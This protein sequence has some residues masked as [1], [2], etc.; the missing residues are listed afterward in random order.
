MSALFVLAL[1]IG[2]AVILIKLVM[3]GNATQ[4]K[5]SYKT[6]GLP[7]GF[8]ASH[9]HKNIAIDAGNGLLWVRDEK[10]FSTVLKASD[11]VRWNIDSMTGN[12]AVTGLPTRANVKLVITSRDLDHP[13]VRVRFN[14]HSDVTRGGGNSNYQEAESWSSRLTA[15]CAR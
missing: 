12:N 15:F 4:E 5:T 10:G 11:V 6:S 8:N 14:G 2:G 13:I 9:S 7:A 1:L 3:K